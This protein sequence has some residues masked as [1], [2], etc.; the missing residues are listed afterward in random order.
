[1]PAAYEY[2]RAAV[3][4]ERDATWALAAVVEHAYCNEPPRAAARVPSQPVSLSLRGTL[5]SWCPQELEAVELGNL[6]A[7]FAWTRRELKVRGALGFCQMS[8]KA[9]E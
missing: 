2:L 6:S 3:Q 1:M 7:S 5:H 4:G 9:A 8:Q